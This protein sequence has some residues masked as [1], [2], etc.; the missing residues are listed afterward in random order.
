MR[1]SWR[2]IWRYTYTSH[3]FSCYA[4]VLSIAAPD[5]RHGH[6]RIQG[7]EGTCQSEQLQ[8]GVPSSALLVLGSG[9]R[10]H[11]G[12]DGQAAAVCDWVLSAAPWR[13]QGVGP[14]LHYHFSSD[15]R[16]ATHLSHMVGT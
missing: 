12:G 9:E 6:S 5:V 13:V 14:S 7:L 16:K 1:M 3:P 2:Y 10:V 8:L 15:Q 4:R 11:S